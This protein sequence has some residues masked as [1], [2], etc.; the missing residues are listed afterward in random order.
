MKLRDELDAIGDLFE[1]RL[2]EVQSAWAEYAKS[3]IGM[4]S[5]VDHVSFAVMRRLNITQV[6]S[7]DKHFA[8]AGFELLF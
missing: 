3:S 4:A 2:Q 5:V 7:N 1:P 8:A 6:F